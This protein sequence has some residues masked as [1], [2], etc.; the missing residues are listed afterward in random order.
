[1][2]TIMLDNDNKFKK[3]R[4]TQN[5][6]SLRKIRLSL[7]FRPDILKLVLNMRLIIK[8]KKD[9]IKS[10]KHNLKMGFSKQ[11][12]SCTQTDENILD[13]EIAVE[14]YI[15]NKKDSYTQTLEI[16]ISDSSKG[17]SIESNEE[18]SSKSWNLQSNGDNEKSIAEQV[19]EVAQSTLQESGMVYVESAGMYYDYKTGYYYNS[20][21]GLYYHT[22]TGCYYY[23]SNEKQT[24]VFHSYPEKSAENESLKAHERRKAKK[25]KKASRSDDVEN[26]TKQFTQVSLRG[27]TALGK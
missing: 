16:T 4:K 12:T 3:C 21:L 26:L 10:L 20:E 15:Q 23:Y 11:K 25:N 9:L 2:E 19:K 5:K 24:F 8:K 1:M 22:D 13:N 17:V 6:F 18:I 14:T 7:K 27:S